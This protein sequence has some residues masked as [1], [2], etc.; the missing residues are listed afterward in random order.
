[1]LTRVAPE[2]SLGK[3]SIIPTLSNY[4]IGVVM[5]RVLTS[6]RLRYSSLSSNGSRFV[7]YSLTI[8]AKYFLI[9]PIPRKFVTQH[10]TQGVNALIR[11]RY[12]YLGDL[13]PENKS[14]SDQF[15]K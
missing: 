6:S 5:L 9:A 1:M 8:P 11:R 12:E 4:E 2:K 7:H 13:S 3:G 10:E 15:V 14:S